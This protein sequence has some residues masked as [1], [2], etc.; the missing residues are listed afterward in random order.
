MKFVK[1]IQAGLTELNI[2]FAESGVSQCEPSSKYIMQFVFNVSS[3]VGEIVLSAQESPL[4]TVQLI[5]SFL[6]RSSFRIDNS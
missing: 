6:F 3:H 2:I 5:G 1:L 4:Y